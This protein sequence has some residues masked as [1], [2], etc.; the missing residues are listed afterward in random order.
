MTVSN[1]SL[2]KRPNGFWYILFTVDGRRKWKSTKCT[3]RSDA[4]KRLTEFNELTKPKPPANRLSSF[5]KEFLQFSS[6]TYAKASVDLF[7]VSLRNLSAISG[8]CMLTE[9]S[10]RHIDHYKASTQTLRQFLLQRSH[11]HFS[12]PGRAHC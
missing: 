5:T 1:L 11:R 12:A 4:L 8:D 6:S 7:R 2:F 10:P 9:I 3:E